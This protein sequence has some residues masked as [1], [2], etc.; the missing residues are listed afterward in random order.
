MILPE[1]PGPVD[2]QKKTPP[3]DKQDG[4]KQECGC[5]SD[6]SP[7]EDGVDTANDFMR[8][9]LKKSEG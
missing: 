1:S 7:E 4:D 6:H 5:D 9:F 3:R 2:D 8:K